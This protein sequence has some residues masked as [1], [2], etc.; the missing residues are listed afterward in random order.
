MLMF[1][2]IWMRRAIYMKRTHIGRGIFLSEDLPKEE[3]GLF[4]SCRQAKKTGLI[5]ATWTF[6]LQVFILTLDNNRIEVSCK[7][8][9]NAL[10]TNDANQTLQDI[11][12]VPFKT[13]RRNS[14]N[15][16]RRNSLTSDADL[17]ISSGTFTLGDEATDVSQIDGSFTFSG[18]T[19]NGSGRLV[20]TGSSTWTDTGDRRSE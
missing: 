18:G 3:S 7:D 11:P 14:D 10:L 5:R 2:N 9:L 19:L 8:H 12:Q 17:Q 15:Y 20:A 13:N 16:D 6:D 1:K 4:Y